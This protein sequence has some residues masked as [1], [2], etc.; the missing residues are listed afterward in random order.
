MDGAFVG[1]VQHDDAV[2]QQVPVN[3]TLS[4]QEAVCHVLDLRLWACAV[5]K[6]HGVAHLRTRNVSIVTV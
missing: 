2:L 3:Q 5:L 1:L 6:T 4:Q